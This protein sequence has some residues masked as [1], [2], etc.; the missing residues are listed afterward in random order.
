MLAHGYSI[1]IWEDS[2]HLPTGHLQGPLQLKNTMNSPILDACF[3][4]LG[5]T[6]PDPGAPRAAHL[7][8]KITEEKD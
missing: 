2:T 7:T 8:S 5:W 4:V 3:Q 1:W 6:F